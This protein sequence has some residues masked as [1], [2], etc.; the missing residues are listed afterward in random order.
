MP[1]RFFKYFSYKVI[2]ERMVR[3]PA[4]VIC[5][6][7]AITLFF[8]LNLPRLSFKTSICDFVIEDLPETAQY[9]DFKKFSVQTRS[10]VLSLKQKMSL[11]LP[12]S[13][14]SGSLPGTHPKSE[15]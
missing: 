9:Q 13:Q 4:G 6:I 3:R 1:Y 10:S 7:A 12:R 15:E 11:T 14:K 5:I 8:A 2:L